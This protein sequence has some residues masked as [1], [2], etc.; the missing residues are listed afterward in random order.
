MSF[1]VTEI[2]LKYWISTFFL[3]DL[4]TLLYKKVSSHRICIIQKIAFKNVRL[5]I[6]TSLGMRTEIKKSKISLLDLLFVKRKYASIYLYKSN[7]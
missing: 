7:T 5:K 3:Y 2:F 1:L 6:V 4:F